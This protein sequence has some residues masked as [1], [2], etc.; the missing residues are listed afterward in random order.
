MDFK[1][2]IR[3]LREER[4]VLDVA[5]AKLE[6]LQHQRRGPGRPPGSVT[7]IHANGTSHVDGSPKSD[8]R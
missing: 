3:Q 1:E 8:G 6:L 2:I 4:E 7:K 5:I